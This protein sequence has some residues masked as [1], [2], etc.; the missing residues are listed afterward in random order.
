GHGVGEAAEAGAHAQLEPGGLVLLP[1][2]RL[3]RAARRVR[4]RRAGL[5]L[6][7]APARAVPPRSLRRGAAALVLRGPGVARDLAGGVPMRHV[8]ARVPFARVSLA[9]HLFTRVSLA[10]H[11]FT[12]VSLA[13]LARASKWFGV[14][15]LLCPARVLAC[16]VCAG[17]NPANRFAFFASTIVL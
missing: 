14:I 7:G 1:D 3:P 5:V 12:R 6:V 4:A 11:L 9:A 16:A 13:A 10:A 8:P 15:A 2:H 17:G